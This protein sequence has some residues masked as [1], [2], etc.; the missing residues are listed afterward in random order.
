MLLLEKVLFLR[1]VPI[2]SGMRLEDLERLSEISE[3]SAV[4]AGHRII[5]QG[6][7]GDRLYLIV[8]GSV[9]VHTEEKDLAVFGPSDYFGELS[10]IDGESRSASVTTVSD[11]LFLEISKEEF[12]VLLARHPSFARA[13]VLALARDLR[14]ARGALQ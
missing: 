6:E 11:S 9:K 10:I 3:E 14:K 12:H 8:E 13:V 1:N 5:R 2:F 7:H 4:P